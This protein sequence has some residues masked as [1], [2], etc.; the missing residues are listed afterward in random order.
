VQYTVNHSETQLIFIEASKIGTLAKAVPKIKGSVK[1]VV[2]WGSAAAGEV[3]SIKKEVSDLLLR[4]SIS[5]HNWHNHLEGWPL[6][7]LDQGHG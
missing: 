7:C 2:Y 1:T 4:P 6:A 3:E 5:S